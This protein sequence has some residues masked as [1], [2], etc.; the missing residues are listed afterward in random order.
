MVSQVV[1]GSLNRRTK[2]RS[3]RSIMKRFSMNVGVAV[4]TFSIGTV[5]WF[6]HPF[7]HTSWTEPLVVT[8]TAHPYSRTAQGEHQYFIT[9]KNVSDRSVRGYSLGYSCSCRGW[10]SNDQP[11]PVNLSFMNP[12]PHQQ[13]LALGESQTIP[14]TLDSTVTPRVWVD[15]VHFNHGENWG[16]NRGHKD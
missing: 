12:V 1:Y 13:L 16:P 15:L 11:Y 3:K 2:L 10:D 9:V 7:R 6:A 4:L 8:M 5:V 14:M